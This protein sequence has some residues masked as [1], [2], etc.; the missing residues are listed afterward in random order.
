M[1]CVDYFFVVATS[2]S[3]SSSCVRS[4]SLLSC[5]FV[6]ETAF[7]LLFFLR[8]LWFYSHQVLACDIPNIMFCEKKKEIKEKKKERKT[9]SRNSGFEKIGTFAFAILSSIRYKYANSVCQTADTLVHTFTSIHMRAPMG[10]RQS[11]SLAES[12]VNFNVDE[13]E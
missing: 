8:S 1:L 9:E 2:L 11:K 6:V 13:S 12:G 10:R 7:R 5:G 4:F 3:W